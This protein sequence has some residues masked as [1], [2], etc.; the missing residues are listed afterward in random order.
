MI[1]SKLA[2]LVCCFLVWLGAEA[3]IPKGTIMIGSG[4][5]FSYTSDRQNYTNQFD[6]HWTPQIGSFIS[7]NFV[8][9]VSPMII[10][11]SAKGH[12]QDSSSSFDIFKSTL[13]LGFGPYAR[14]YIKIG[15]KASIFIHAAPSIAATWNRFSAK[16]DDPYERTISA[17]WAVGPGLSFMMSKSVALETSIYYNGMW[18]RSAQFTKGNLL[19]ESKAYVNHGMVFNVGFQVYIDRKRKTE[20]TKPQ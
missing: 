18:Y 14:Y 8:L 2:L 7:K 15:P 5:G 20:A 3:Q 13:S 17:N 4:L 16:S 12:Y 19:S 1:R 10:Y 9:G 11:S 6:F